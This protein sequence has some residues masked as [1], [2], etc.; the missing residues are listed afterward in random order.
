MKNNTVIILGIACALFVV[1]CGKKEEKQAPVVYKYTTA[2]VYTQMCAKCHGDNGEG[3]PK[4]KGPAL[5]T[6]TFNELRMGIID[7]KMGGSGVNSGGTDHEI[8]EHNMKKI[9]DKGMDYDTDD[10]AKYIFDNFNK[11]K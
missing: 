1:G 4:K 7:I 8:M 3:V 10:M 6:Q 2:E 9:I 11:N 5:D